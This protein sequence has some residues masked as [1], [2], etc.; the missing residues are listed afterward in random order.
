[1]RG[2]RLPAL[3]WLAASAAWA[4]A[5]RSD[6]LYVNPAALVTASRLVGLAGASTGSRKHREHPHQLRRRRRPAPAP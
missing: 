6:A 1:M 2:L 4:Q 5:P 3:V